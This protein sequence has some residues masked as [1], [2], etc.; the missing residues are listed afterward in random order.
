MADA[1]YNAGRRRGSADNS[2]AIARAIDAASP[3]TTVVI[4]E[5]LLIAPRGDAYIKI[6]KPIELNGVGWHS[7]LIPDRSIPSRAPVISIIG[8][9]TGSLDFHGG[10]RNLMIGH[11]EGDAYRFPREGGHAMRLEASVP[12]G[13]LE[14]FEIFNVRTREGR[15][16]EDSYGLY[17]IHDS[18]QPQ[19]AIYNF[20]VRQC[21]IMGGVRMIQVADSV[22]ILNSLIYGRNAVDI[23]VRPGAGNFNF[24]G[25]NVSTHGGFRLR[26][27]V[28]AV[29]D[30]NV[31]AQQDRSNN[32]H[33][34]LVDIDGDLGRLIGVL[35]TGNRIQTE[36]G[37]GNPWLLRL[38]N[39][40][41]PMIWGN[42]FRVP[43]P[44]TPVE[45]TAACSGA[46]V[47]PNNW[48][49]EGATPWVNRNPENPI[50]TF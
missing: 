9:P 19:G 33:N 3:G 36:S 46:K 29:L 13:G 17:V 37:V 49:I 39:V 43:E 40:Q 1:P 23:D 7:Q 35:L 4:P 5:P 12:D 28:G 31:F 10:V 20:T 18:P 48:D 25:N 15:Y 41:D 44:Y 32:P 27:G 16:G 2:A 22:R 47:G 8:T 42:S 11:P 30:S 45:F 50:H 38:N 24:R 34:T 26:A 14:N 6:T 21:T